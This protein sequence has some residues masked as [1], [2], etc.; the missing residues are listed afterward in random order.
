MTSKPVKRGDI[1]SLLNRLVEVREITNFRTNLFRAAGVAH[2][3]WEVTVVTGSA[4]L[5]AV[6]ARVEEA[7]R[8][9]GIE[10]RVTVWP[11]RRPQSR[12]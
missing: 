1:V 4:D 10:I 8:P 6:Q 3:A 2:A 11:V 7:L 9:L 12:G 5:A